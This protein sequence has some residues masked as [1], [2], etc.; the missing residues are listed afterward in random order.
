MKMKSIKVLFM[1]YVLSISVSLIAQDSCSSIGW[2]NYDGQTFVGPPTGGGNATPIEVTTFASLKAEAESIGPKVIYVMND[3]GSGYVGN[4]GD[5]LYVKSD[6]TIIGNGGVTIR[7]SWQMNGVNNIVIRNLTISGPGNT[8]ASQNWDAVNITNSKRIWIDH[9]KIMDGEDGNFDVVRGSDNV[10]VTW[11]IFTYS[12][13]GIHNFSNLI[14]SSDTEPESWGKLNITFANC[15]WKDVNSRTPRARYGKIH[16]LNCYYSNSSGARAGFKSN[17]RVEGSYFDS[18]NTPV[19]LISPGAE[20]GIFTIGCSYVSCTGNTGDVSV[21]G[22]TAFI[23]PYDYTIHPVDDVKSLVTNAECGAGPTMDSATQCGCATSLPVSVTGLTVSPTI[24]SIVEGNTIQLAATVL[25]SNASNNAVTW[26][27]SNTAIAT[28]NS[29]GLVTGITPGVVEITATTLDGGFN[30]NSVITVTILCPSIEFQA[31][32]G[33]ISSGGTVDSNNAGFTG[34]G[35]VNTPNTLGAWFEITVNVPTAGSYAC[36]FRYAN[37]TSIDRTQ[38]VLV[39]GVTQINS[40]AFPFTGA[41]TT[42]DKSNFSLDLNQGNNIVRFE[43]LTSS[44]AANL[45]RLDIYD[46]G[47]LNLEPVN[48]AFKFDLYPNP[49]INLLTIEIAPLFSEE[50]II[51]LY[52]ISGKLVLEKKVTGASNTL[53]LKNLKAGVYLVSITNGMN[54]VVKRIIKH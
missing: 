17:V 29:M 23:P 32:T 26:S 53:N 16:V 50:S 28:V 9:C 52:D 38:S 7:C 4:T 49:I 30:A 12:A 33:T 1:I 39:N 14:G 10:S 15:W 19:D 27:S 6:K 13:D 54:K 45:D 43:S 2:A 36:S 42:W 20:A 8:N 34:T 24:G 35:F 21:G 25:P 31:E 11:C 40:L 41:W 22:Y 51:Q 46:C 37:G 44:G 3:V 47:L 5:V 18:I 48:Q